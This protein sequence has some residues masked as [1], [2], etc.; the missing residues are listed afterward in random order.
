MVKIAPIVS[1]T[2]GRQEPVIISHDNN[3]YVVK[4]KVGFNSYQDVIKLV[5]P[6]DLE[7]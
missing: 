3:G 5:I 4:E 2:V 6:I 7:P 1:S